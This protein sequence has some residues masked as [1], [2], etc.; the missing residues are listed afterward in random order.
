MQQV[1]VVVMVVVIVGCLNDR[2]SAFA[3]V[4]YGKTSDYDNDYEYDLQEQP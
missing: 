1:I 3:N 2:R 4:G